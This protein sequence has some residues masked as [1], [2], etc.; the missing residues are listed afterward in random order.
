MGISQETV[1]EVLR[2]SNVYDVIS[3]YIN[4]EKTGS[5]Y[6]ALCPFHTE[7]TPSFMVSPQKNIFKCFGCGK[8][9]NAVTFLM[10]YEGISFGEAVIKLAEK[11]NIPVR[12]TGSDEEIKQRK[13][14][15]YLSQKR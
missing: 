11:Y 4:L 7:K 3:D 5:N 13:R 9:G 2:V 12:F 10:E 1:E 15:L 14:G 6:R 8:S